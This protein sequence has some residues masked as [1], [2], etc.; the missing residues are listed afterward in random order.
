MEEKKP[1]MAVDSKCLLLV[2]SNG[3]LLGSEGTIDYFN[4]KARSGEMFFKAIH[5]HKGEEFLVNFSQVVHVQLANR[6]DLRD[7][8]ARVIVPP[9][10]NN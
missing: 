7:G 3:A 6:N 9:G 2:M 4:L 8:P 5:P 1:E 10:M